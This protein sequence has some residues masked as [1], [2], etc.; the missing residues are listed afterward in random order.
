MTRPLQQL[1]DALRQELQHHGELLARL[2]EIPV[3]CPDLENSDAA[4]AVERQTES[5]LATQRERERLQLQLAWAAEQPDACSFEELIPVL[6]PAYRPLLTALVQENESLRRRVGDRLRESLSW[7]DRA[8]E[9]SGRTLGV[10]AFP[11]ISDRDVDVHA[12]ANNGD[13]RLSLLFTA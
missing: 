13:N 11:Q 12:A 9:V 2:D 1:I 7:L 5:L 3:A 4:R 8:C 6:P 10:I